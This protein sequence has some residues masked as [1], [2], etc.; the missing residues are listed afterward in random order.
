M[1]CSEGHRGASTDFY[2]PL[3]RPK[4]ALE[5]L[6]NGQVIVRG[7]IQSNWLWETRAE[8]LARGLDDQI[9]EKF[10]PDGNGL[11]RADQVLPERSSAGK[12]QKEDILLQANGQSVS[13]LAI[14]EELIDEATG[15]CCEVSR[16]SAAGDKKRNY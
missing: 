2:L 15:A 5:A 3:E 4:R 6:L 9:L 7:T 13:T 12:I 16:D 10:C 8:C 11:L 1:V 14:L